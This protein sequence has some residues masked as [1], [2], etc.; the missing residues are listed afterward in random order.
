MEV[1]RSIDELPVAIFDRINKSGD[2]QLL[3]IGKKKYTT[4]QLEKCW[5]I[6]YDEFIQEFGISQQF[7]TYLTKMRIAIGY[8]I[9]AYIEGDKPAINLARA[10][11]VEAEAIYKETNTTSNNNIYAIVSKYMGFRINPN[12]IST[13]EF[14]NYLR[15][16]TNDNGKKD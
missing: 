12:E 10:N 5:E 14:Y 16:A 6:I 1:Y 9:K 2:L 11:V 3:V 8:Y 13:R 4:Q 15:L 7:I